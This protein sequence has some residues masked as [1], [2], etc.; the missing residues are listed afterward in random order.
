[1]WFFRKVPRFTQMHSFLDIVAQDLFDKCEGD[2][3]HLTVVFPNKRASLFFNQALARIAQRPVW[4]P[5]YLTISEL[6]QQMSP[7]TLADHV[8]LI[9][10]LYQTYVKQTGSQETLDQFY[11]WGEI[12][13]S[14]FDDIDNNLADPSRLFRNMEDLDELTRYDY[15]SEEQKR[16]IQ[17]FFEH[18]NP[19]EKTELKEKFLSVWNHLLPIYDQFCQSLEAQG[20]AYDGMLKREVLEEHSSSTVPCGFPARTNSFAFVGFNVL[21]KSEHQLLKRIKEEQQAWFY[22][23]FDISYLKPDAEAGRFIR[24]NLETFGNELPKDHPC[25]AQLNQPKDITFVASPTETAQAHYVSQWLKWDGTDTA[26]VLCNEANLQSVLHCIPADDPS[27]EGEPLTY[28]VTMGF[29]LAQTAIASFVEALLDLQ[30]HGRTHRSDTWRHTQ[31]TNL[32]KH[33]LAAHIAGEQLVSSILTNIRQHNILFPTRSLFEESDLLTKLF[34]PTE[35]NAS[36]LRLLADILQVVGQSYAGSNDQLNIESTFNAYTIVNRLISIQESGLLH[37]SQE[38]LARLLR[39]II[40]GKTIPF[41][42]EPAEGIQI[43]GVLETRNLDFRHVIMLG[44]NE[45]NLPKSDHHSSF[46]PYNLREAYGLTTIER[47]NSL[48]AYYFYRLLQRADNITLLYNNSTEGLMR[49]EMS[50]FM[51]QLLTERPGIRQ[52]SILAGNSFYPTRHFQVEK[53]PEVLAKLRRRFCPQPPLPQGS[54]TRVGLLTPSS[55]NTYINCPLQFYFH[56]V[57]GLKSEDEVTEEIG[58]DMFGTLF[59]Y[60]MEHIYS[61]IFPLGKQLQASD[62]QQLASNEQ[63]LGSLVDEAFNVEFFKVDEVHKHQRPRYNGEQLLNRQVILTYLQGQLRQDADLCPMTVISVEDRSYSMDIPIEEGRTETVRLGG[64]IDRIDSFSRNGQECL[65]VVDYKTSSKAQKSNDLEQLFDASQ[66][67]RPYHVLQAYCY[68]DIVSEQETRPVVPML[69]Y[70]KSKETYS[71]V[72][73]F[74]KDCKEE[75]HE[76]LVSHIRT[77]FNPSVPFTQD[78]TGNACQY[79]DFASFCQRKVEQDV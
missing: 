27:A 21:S 18:F 55:L 15:L 1:M 79:C 76:L 72:E 33:P 53:T 19:K 51:M 61:D 39:Q 20:Y 43:M 11:S 45:G 14:D 66:A 4:T 38:T 54:G 67:H 47:Q 35:D 46:I 52:Q 37:V 69:T 40:Q 75:F 65:R 60:C 73:D 7:L 8:L 3:R 36:L 29:P 70:V 58:N 30:L 22:W 10:L 34:T 57:A 64:S 16:S 50:R 44:V 17:Q 56:Y 23:D 32:L 31:V 68:A 77:I 41:H 62:L 24:Q 26:I 25:Y 78:P 12:M 28:N 5:R 2:F 13:L 48:Y 59:H 63:V 71:P 74:S 49:G 6:F 42:G 9:C